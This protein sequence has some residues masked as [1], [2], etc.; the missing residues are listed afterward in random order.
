MD[1][2][3]RVRVRVRVRPWMPELGAAPGQ[4]A[5]LPRI[6]LRASY[7]AMVRV[8]VTARVRVRLWFGSG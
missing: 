1:A 5:S 4:C 3:A 8:M 7:T 2:R 6:S